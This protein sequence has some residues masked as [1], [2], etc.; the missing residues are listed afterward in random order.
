MMIISPSA[1]F[2]KDQ[3]RSYFCGVVAACRA[4]R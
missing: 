2:T 1:N 4:A 3:F